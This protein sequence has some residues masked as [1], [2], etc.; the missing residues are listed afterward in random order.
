MSFIAPFHTKWPDGTTK[1]YRLID[2]EP[3]NAVLEQLS[4]G[5]V[6][7]DSYSIGYDQQGNIKSIHIELEPSK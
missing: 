4:Q 7:M 1:E 5:Q 3:L 6:V 2:I